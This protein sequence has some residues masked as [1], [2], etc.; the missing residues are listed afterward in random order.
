MLGT[1]IFNDPVHGFIE[2]PR[3]IVLQLV[4]HPVVQRLRHIGQVSVSPMVYPGATHTRFSHTL[5]AVHLTQ[6]ALNT[7]RNKG[8]QI[9]DDEYDATLM[10]ILLHDVGHGPFSHTFE[11][12]I[13]DGLSHERM[14]RA[15]MDM[16]NDE[17]DGQL[18]EAIQIFEGTHP[19]AFLHDLISSQLDMD[20]MDYLCRDS[21]FTGV[22]EGMIGSDRIIKTLQ[23]ANN[24]LVVEQKGIY[25][26]EKFL[27]ARRLMY[28]QV[29]L[30]KTVLAAEFLLLRAFERA[31]WLYRKGLLTKPLP[32]FTYFWDLGTTTLDQPLPAEVLDRFV[33]L[34]DHDI[35]YAIKLWLHEPDLCLAEICRRF[36]ARSLPRVQFVPEPP[37]P[38]YIAQLRD[39]LAI[40]WKIDDE[41]AALLAFSGSVQNS[42][43]V[44]ESEAP[45]MILQK[46][47]S[48]REISQAADLSN[49]AALSHKI[50][51]HFLCAVREAFE[52]DKD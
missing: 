10:A 17:C 15:I 29:Y 1:K 47:G 4:D 19:K 42:A 2:L 26:V 48:L 18:S 27:I 24:R 46:D 43:Y 33:S 41:A 22:V 28:W 14:S 21:F 49:I 3:G 30:H 13:V 25:S 36:F 37:N 7:L 5:G 44:E 51:K 6:Q 16:L 35:I 12:A 50:T 38:D 39:T 20:R 9:T 45:I 31:R 32:D 40:R 52:N 23:V 34:T 11:R 8:V